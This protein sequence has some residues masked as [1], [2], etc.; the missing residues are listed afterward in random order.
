MTDLTL[1]DV[2]ANELIGYWDANNSGSVTQ[3]GGFVS[4]WLDTTSRARALVQVTGSFQP[5]VSGSILS[6]D[7]VDNYLAEAVHSATQVSSQDLPD[8]SGNAGPGTA[9]S[10]TGLS[11]D[12]VTGGWVIGNDGRQTITVPGTQIPSIVFTDSTGAT[13][14]DELIYAGHLSI[15]G[16]VVDKDDGSIWFVELTVPATIRNVD[17]T[18]GAQISSFTSASA[19]GIAQRANGNLIVSTQAGVCTEF[20]RAGVVVGSGFTMGGNPDGISVW[21]HPITGREW[22]IG[23]Q[24]GSSLLIWDLN[25]GATILGG[26][27]NIPVP[28]FTQAASEGVYFD[29][30]NA[31]VVHNGSFHSTGTPGADPPISQLRKYDIAGI[32]SLSCQPY[33]DLFFVGN[34]N[35]WVSGTLC[36]WQSNNPLSTPGIGIYVTATTNLRSIIAETASVL[37]NFTTTPLVRGIWHLS[38][39]AVAE[40]VELR[41]NGT[42]VA[43][44]QSISA[45]SG[46]RI[47]TRATVAGAAIETGTPTRFSSARV[48]AIVNRCG[49]AILETLTREQIEGILSWDHGLEGLLDSAH[50]YKLTRPI[51]D[52][53]S[54]AGPSAGWPRR[55]HDP[56]IFEKQPRPFSRKYFNELKAAEAAQRAAQER[57]DR[58]KS[59]QA[60]QALNRAAQEA[61]EAIAHAKE[62]EVDLSRMT[63]ALEAARG[64]SD[65]AE[66]IRQADLAIQHAREIQEEDEAIALLMLH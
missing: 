46:G 10:A 44:A 37:T 32:N 5:A 64:A 27:V 41:L 54:D 2:L 48:S 17:R 4:Q 66:T 22:L 31:W 23:Y 9:F 43:A 49:A 38:V 26:T 57:A 11:Y 45:I 42:L 56:D 60:K 8:A 63:A 7:G 55:Y 28:G 52:S 18:T 61:A 16:V 39:D 51:S 24:E 12:W 20:T 3:S 62:T 6:F 1:S 13:K 47:H 30:I 50:P 53:S 25:A 35:S 15:Q 33:F 14:T 36:L 21:S 40:T 34:I 58:L 59:R 65:L 19:N 29:G